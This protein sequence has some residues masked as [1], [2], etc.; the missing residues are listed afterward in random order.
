[1]SGVL[2]CLHFC[3]P[4]V[5]RQSSRTHLLLCRAHLLL[6]GAASSQAAARPK[7]KLEELMERDLANKKRAAPSSTP[8]PAL[9]KVPQ[10]ADAPWVAKGL[11]V[12]VC[13]TATCCWR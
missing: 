7:S 8:A 11:V 3:T 9:P 10:R 1:M 13:P 4:V 2:A 5:A 12:K 6:A